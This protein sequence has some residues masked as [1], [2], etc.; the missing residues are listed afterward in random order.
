M[1][2]GEGGYPIEDFLEALTVIGPVAISR[3]RTLAQ[4]QFT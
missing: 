2:R 3:K 1:E 4:K